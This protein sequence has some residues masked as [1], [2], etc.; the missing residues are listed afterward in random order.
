MVRKIELQHCVAELWI[1]LPDLSMTSKITPRQEFLD[2][3]FEDAGTFTHSYFSS[4][5]GM[6]VSH[7]CLTVVETA[8]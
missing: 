7:C 4:S 1:A 3:A 6:R 8:P 2:Q 5:C